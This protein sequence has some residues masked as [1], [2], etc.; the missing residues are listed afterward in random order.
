MHFCED[1]L[2]FTDYGLVR[3][4]FDDSKYTHGIAPYDLDTRND[5][6]EVPDYVTD[7]F[8]RLY[9]AEVS[10]GEPFSR[11]FSRTHHI[12]TSSPNLLVCHRRIQLLFHTW[13]T[14]NSSTA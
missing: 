5:V 3:T 10:I 7:I 6:Q 4:P 8:Q 1:I 2:E 9:D 13:K 12:L 11:Y 14:K